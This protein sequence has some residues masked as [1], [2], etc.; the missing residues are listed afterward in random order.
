[1]HENLQKLELEWRK[2]NAFSTPPQFGARE[3]DFQVAESKNVLFFSFE[4]SQ[5]RPDARAEFPRTEGFGHIVVGSQIEP[6]DLFSFMCFG[7]QNNDGGTHVCSPEI[8]AN[9]KAIASRKHHIQNNQIPSGFP[10]ATAG[11]FSI[12]HH[13][14]LVTFGRKIIFEEHRDIA[15]VF[16]HQ[17]SSHFHLPAGSRML[18]VLPLS[19]GLSI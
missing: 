18:N 16:N 1:V 2:L 8:A 6:K 13:F 11:C 19:D 10:S 14:N 3:I 5:H 17:D 7:G 15:I 12:L 9:V 4:P